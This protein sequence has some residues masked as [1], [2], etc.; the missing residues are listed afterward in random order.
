M[1]RRAFDAQVTDEAIT[2]PPYLREYSLNLNHHTP[3]PVRL[4][5]RSLGLPQAPSNVPV[6]AIA[7]AKFGLGWQ[8]PLIHGGRHSRLQALS[9]NALIAASL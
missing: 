6:S 3:P 5:S 7:D 4:H 9:V 1:R 8:V 2:I